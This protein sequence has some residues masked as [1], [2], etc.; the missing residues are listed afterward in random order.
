MSVTLAQLFHLLSA[1][2]ERH[3]LF[4]SSRVPGDR[5]LVACFGA[6]GVL[7]VLSAAWPPLRRVLG[8][9]RMGPG[10]WLAAVAGSGGAFLANELLKPDSPLVRLA[11][12]ND[13]S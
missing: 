1:R 10:D 3:S 8:N 6:S 12:R 9:A 13:S 4:G 11:R 2:S 7:Q 5:T